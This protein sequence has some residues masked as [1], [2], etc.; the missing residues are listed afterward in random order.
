VPSTDAE[1]AEGEIDAAERKRLARMG[2]MTVQ[3]AHARTPSP[4]PDLNPSMHP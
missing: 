3:P 2:V 1:V 4:N